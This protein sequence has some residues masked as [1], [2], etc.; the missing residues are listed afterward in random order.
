[1]I[2]E[3]GLGQ[4]VSAKGDVYSYGILLLEIIAR[5]R[6]TDSMF[7]GDLNLRSW[8]RSSLPERLANVVDDLLLRN[9]R[10]E[11]HECLVSFIHV[12]LLCTNESPQERPTMRHVGRRLE[13]LRSTFLGNAA[14]TSHLT[15]TISDLVHKVQTG[16]ASGD[17]Q[18]ST[19]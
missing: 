16:Y 6:P 11:Q 2:A 8:V 17:S 15:S 12:G 10:R 19:Y 3:Y 9:M 13:I 18:S 4:C 5:K 14:T 7:V 1:L